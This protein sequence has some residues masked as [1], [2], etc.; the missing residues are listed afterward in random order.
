MTIVIDAYNF[1]KYVTKTSFVSDQEIREWISTFKE[2]ARFRNNT[3]IIVFDAGPGLYQMT[4]Y[5]GKVT[6][7]Y[8]GQM[9]TADDVIQDFLQQNQGK[10]L[11][12]VTSDREICVFAEKV[13]IVSVGSDDFYKIFNHVMSRQENYEQKIVH[14]LHKITDQELDDLDTLMEEGSRNLVHYQDHKQEQIPFR[15]RDGRKASKTDKRLLKK[16]EKI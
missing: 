5:Y 13:N 11:L 7:I 14:T 8:S 4:E 9:K 15:L 6:V 12:L 16:I 10:D 2:Y 1:I 3:V